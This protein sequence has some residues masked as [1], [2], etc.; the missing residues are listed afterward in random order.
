MIIISTTSS[1]S[2]ITSITIVVS[3]SITTNSSA[4]AISASSDLYITGSNNYLY[5]HGYNETGQA[6]RFKVAISGS[7]FQ[8][9]EET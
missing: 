8:V 1:S 2:C 5:L 4:S 9:A 3:R 6:V 7:L